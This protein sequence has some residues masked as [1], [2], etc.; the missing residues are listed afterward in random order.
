MESIKA[1]E[2]LSSA[3]KIVGTTTMNKVTG[4]AKKM[5]PSDNKVIK[6]ENTSV[7]KDQQKNKA[8]KVKRPKIP[9]IYV[10]DKCTNTEETVNV[11]DKGKITDIQLSHKPVNTHNECEDAWYK[12]VASMI[13]FT[14]I[15][16]T[17][18]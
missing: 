15:S 5:Q 11:K 9:K 3:E 14:G 1:T 12:H 7:G 16:T 6:R 17:N 4:S 8:K 10:Q 18:T 2:T 13:E